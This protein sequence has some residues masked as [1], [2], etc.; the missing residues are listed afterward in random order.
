M[1]NLDVF[2]CLFVKKHV[3]LNAIGKFWKIQIQGEHDVY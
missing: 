3:F 2:P 1:G